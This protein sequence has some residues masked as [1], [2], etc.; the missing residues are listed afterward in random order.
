MRHKPRAM[1]HEA[2]GMNDDEQRIVIR[3][4][5]FVIQYSIFIIIF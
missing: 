1:S 4:S 5:K 3:H 2:I